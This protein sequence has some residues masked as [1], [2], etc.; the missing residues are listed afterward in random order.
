MNV[1]TALLQRDV[2][3]EGSDYEVV[4]RVIEKISLD[5]RDQPS[6]EEIAGEV[7]DTPTGLQKLFTRWAGLSPKAFLQAVTLDHA[8]RLLD[9]GMP[10]LDAALELGMSGPGRLHD[11]FVTHEA[12]SP[13]EYKA[14][15]AG[16]TM[17][18]GFHLSPFGQA[19]VMVTE[20]GLAGLA[21]CDPGDERT[22]F[23][24]MASRWPNADY[25][26]DMAATAPYAARVFDPSRWRA[27]EPLRVV[28][29]GTDFQVR[30]WDALLKIPMGRACAYSDIAERIGK[31]TASRAVGAAVGANPVSFVVP[32]HRAVG[33]SGALTGY[34]WGLTR[35]RAILGWEAGQLSQAD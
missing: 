13:G 31:P 19:L 22:A 8:R 6:L 17:R 4:R 34:H 18:Y 25:E 5:Y 26:E 28:L 15:G 2:T 20:R 30:V 7:G 11:L 32:C 16:L 9:S 21:F 14:R 10:L 23:E 35:K 27:E 3:P 1:Q 33:K 24:D 12:I 29:I